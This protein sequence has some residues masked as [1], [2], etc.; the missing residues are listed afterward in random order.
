MGACERLP[1]ELGG[2]RGGG[3]QRASRGAAV[4]ARANGCSW[5]ERTCTYAAESGHLEVLQ[6]AHANG[7]PWDKSTCV[8][9]ADNRH[10]ELLNWAIANGCPQQ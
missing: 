4:V 8:N 7:C 10:L 5:N 2:V 3:V 9:A 1:M 6:W